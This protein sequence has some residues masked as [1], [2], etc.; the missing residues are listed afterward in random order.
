MSDRTDVADR[1]RHLNGAYKEAM[2]E[3]FPEI[4]VIK[5]MNGILHAESEKCPYL[6]NRVK[7]V[8]LHSV[9]TKVYSTN[10]CKD[11]LSGESITQLKANPYLLVF[12]SVTRTILALDRTSPARLRNALDLGMFSVLKAERAVFQ[13]VPGGFNHIFVDYLRNVKAL[14]L[15]V[16]LDQAAG[17]KLT[18]GA[19]TATRMVAVD[20]LGFRT[21]RT[22]YSDTDVTD[23]ELL[24]FMFS[25][26]VQS[27]CGI[28]VANLPS[29]I[30]ERLGDDLRV[31]V[32]GPLSDEV[33]QTMMV[34]L[35]DGIPFTDAINTALAL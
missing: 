4:H 35:S 15:E 10:I 20:L 33:L 17:S 27:T 14:Y 2:F 16:L 24:H 30:A 29:K 32:E 31:S 25:N 7:S 3:Y 34:L 19:S 18:V 22:P 1:L 21:A 9:L 26:A 23:L 8:L 28:A 13:N 12:L 5:D 11:C 6:V